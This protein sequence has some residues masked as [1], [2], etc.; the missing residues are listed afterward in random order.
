[1]QNFDH[2]VE[3]TNTA[4]NSAGSAA[5]ENAAYMESLEAKSLGLAKHICWKPLRA[6][7]TK[8]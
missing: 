8:V 3:A 4:L 1:M 6:S 5:R 2:A 7:T